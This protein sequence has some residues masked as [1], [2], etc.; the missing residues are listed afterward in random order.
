MAKKLVKQT[1]IKEPHDGGFNA[2]D[3]NDVAMSAQL[4]GINMLT[5]GFDMKPE[6]LD[7]QHEA[8]LSYGS[9]VV[10]C[11]IDE[12]TQTVAALFRYE[13]KGSLARRSLLKCVAEYVVI[14]SIP[15]EAPQAAARGFC[16]NVGRFAAY[17]Y[18][19]TQ[20]AQLFW[21]AGV[22]LPPLPAIASTAH[23]PKKKDK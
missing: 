9:E 17:P 14:Y 16:R 19:R 10:S 8:K 22:V 15:N 18:F 20:V 3:Y 23:I 11:G 1:E 4:A 7:H 6:F 12:E 21:A 13:V 5:C 2:A